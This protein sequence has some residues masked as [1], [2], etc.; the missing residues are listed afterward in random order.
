MNIDSNR[1]SRRK[2]RGTGKIPASLFTVKPME[3]AIQKSR[4]GNYE[5]SDF[6]R[7][8]QMIAAFI[9]QRLGKVV[10][11]VMERF[12]NAA[13][14]AER[15]HP[16]LKTAFYSF[17]MYGWRDPKSVRV[18]DL[19]YHANPPLQGR[20]LAALEACLQAR[21]V[22]M[23]VDDVHLR[24]QRIRGRD[25]LRDETVTMRDKNAAAAL[26]PGMCFLSWMIPWG[27]SWQAIG[28]AIMVPAERADALTI[29]IKSLAESFSCTR[30]E[31]PGRHAAHL[32]WVIQRVAHMQP[33]GA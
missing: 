21:M 31:L 19:F 11:I 29:A 13:T 4:W 5:R 16:A 7:V 15:N 30:L 14:P 28:S 25:L 22:L 9:T 24:K 3:G 23:T 10:P 6:Q 1:S 20:Q 26:R 12:F 2:R 27:T 8:E 17:L 32:F 18:V 33:P